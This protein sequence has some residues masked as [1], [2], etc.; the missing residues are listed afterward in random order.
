MIGQAYT[1]KPALTLPHRP[2]GPKTVPVKNPP[3]HP[4]MGYPIDCATLF[5]AE[6]ALDRPDPL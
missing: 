1:S 3:T 6:V 5:P 4:A 2:W